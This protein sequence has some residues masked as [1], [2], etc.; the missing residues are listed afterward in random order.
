MGHNL[1]YSVC[2]PALILIA[3]AST[4]NTIE[5][6]D[7]FFTGNDPGQTAISVRRTDRDTF[8]VT[9]QVLGANPRE[10]CDQYSGLHQT[11][12]KQE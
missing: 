6:G 9:A 10:F 4:A 2:R 1:T 5:A 8:E 3:L 7:V 11:P 12:E